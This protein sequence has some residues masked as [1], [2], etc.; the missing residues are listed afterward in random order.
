MADTEKRK[1][2]PHPTPAGISQFEAAERR[3]MLR[4]QNQPHATAVSYNARQQTITIELNTG[5]SWSLPVRYLQGLNEANARQLAKVEISSGGY[6][7][8]WP[9]L[10]V[11]LSV[12]G[13]L[14]GRYGSEAFMAQQA[15]RS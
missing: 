15:T 1:R 7:L 2:D 6:G 14:A 10:D 12:G 8:Y 9:D 13:L 11:D 4:Q 3:G 5:A